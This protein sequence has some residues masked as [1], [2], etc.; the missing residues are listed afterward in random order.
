MLGA[1]GPWDYEQATWPASLLLNSAE[2]TRG[3]HVALAQIWEVL[4]P[5]LIPTSDNSRNYGV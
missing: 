1:G 2:A 5:T 3:Q 4:C